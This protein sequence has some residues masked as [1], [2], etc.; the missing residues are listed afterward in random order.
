MLWGLSKARFQGEAQQ[1]L[2]QVGMIPG[3]NAGGSQGLHVIAREES[4]FLA[5]DTLAPAVRVAPGDEEEGT[6]LEGELVVL[7]LRV[8]VQG[9]HCERSK[10]RAMEPPRGQ[11]QTT[12]LLCAHSSPRAVI[13]AQPG[14]PRQRSG[15]RGS[16]GPFST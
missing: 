14:A 15:S 9:H 13:W 3:G 6:G 7:L 10:G 11:E 2:I 16:A 4:R 8:G 12:A 5:H 1:E